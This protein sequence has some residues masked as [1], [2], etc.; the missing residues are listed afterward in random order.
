VYSERR[1]DVYVRIKVAISSHIEN[2]DRYS[3]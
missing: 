2:V 1:V 3:T